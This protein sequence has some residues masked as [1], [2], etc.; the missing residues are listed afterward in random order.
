MYFFEQNVMIK[1]CNCKAY[2]NHMMQY[3]SNNKSCTTIKSENNTNKEI[4][5]CILL[6]KSLFYFSCFVVF[7][8]NYR[9]TNYRFLKIVSCFVYKFSQKQFSFSKIPIFL[10]FGS[11]R[12]HCLDKQLLLC[13]V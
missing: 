8:Y 11:I 7:F 3:M 2:V 4:R 12:R 9:A 10:L 6:E 5:N 13:F 1:S